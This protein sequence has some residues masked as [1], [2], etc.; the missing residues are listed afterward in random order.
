MFVVVLKFHVD[1]EDPIQKWQNRT[2]GT[3]LAPQ[4]GIDITTLIFDLDD[5][6]PALKIPSDLIAKH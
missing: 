5:V 2:L 3:G 4:P 6:L 1:A